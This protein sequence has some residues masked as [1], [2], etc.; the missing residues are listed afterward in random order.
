M[1]S[2]RSYIWC[3]CIHPM[4]ISCSQI[5]H[6][7]STQSIR[8]SSQIVRGDFGL[9]AMLITGITNFV[10][11]ISQQVQVG[12]TLSEVRTTSVGTPQGSVLSTVLYLLYPDSCQRQFPGPHLIKYADDTALVS[13]LEGDETEHRTALN[14]FTLWC[15]PSHRIMNTSKTKDM[16]IDF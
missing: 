1:Q 5:S 15:E 4:C 10:T 11:Y 3:T 16:V 6:Q 2:S 8:W 9:D 7:H 14:D 12:N 13:L